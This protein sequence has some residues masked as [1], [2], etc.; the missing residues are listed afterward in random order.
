MLQ[1]I[2]LHIADDMENEHMNPKKA[3]SIIHCEW[4]QFTHMYEKATTDANICNNSSF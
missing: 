1:P 2:Y 4:R 3:Q